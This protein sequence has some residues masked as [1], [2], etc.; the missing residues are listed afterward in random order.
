MTARIIRLAAYR[1]LTPDLAA[2]VRRNERLTRARDAGLL[3]LHQ[4]LQDEC[5]RIA[6]VPGADRSEVVRIEEEI[7]AWRRVPIADVTRRFNRGNA[8]GQ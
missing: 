6:L 2:T 1:D 4:A 8:D 3:E 5:D 7:A